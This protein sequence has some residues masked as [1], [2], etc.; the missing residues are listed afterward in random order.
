MAVKINNTKDRVRTW[1]ENYPH[2][3]ED[4]NR[5]LAN[6]WHDD[7]LK[8][9]RNLMEMSSAEFLKYM[10]ENKLTNPESVRRCRQKL[11]QDHPELRGV[12]YEQRQENQ[13][14]VREE[15]GYSR[16]PKETL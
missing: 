13:E 14:D 1:L 10:A 11:Q 8:L 2:L 6:I 4:D 7:I 12:V 15:L 9:G 5:L 3:R 16:R